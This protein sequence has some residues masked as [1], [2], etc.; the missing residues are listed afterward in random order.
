MKL[1]FLLFIVGL[2]VAGGAS[3]KLYAQAERN[4]MITLADRA[5]G[6]ASVSV[7][8]SDV[9]PCGALLGMKFGKIQ[10][11]ITFVMEMGPEGFEPRSVDWE[12]AGWHF[13][14]TP[15]SRTAFPPG[16]SQGTLWLV[17]I[18]GIQHPIV[19]DP[20]AIEMGR[21]EVSVVPA[22]AVPSPPGVGKGE[23]RVPM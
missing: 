5:D 16:R 12:D 17:R 1:R 22:D 6:G 11:N 21:I 2:L 19:R 23:G 4:F 18:G 9:R 14:L 15:D 3:S 10:V 20:R 8:C 13:N 7:R